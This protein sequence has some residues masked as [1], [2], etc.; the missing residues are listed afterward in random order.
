MILHCDGISWSNLRQKYGINVLALQRGETRISPP[1]G[2]EML[3]EGDVLYVFGR[4]QIIQSL[5]NSKTNPFMFSINSR[6]VLSF[7]ISLNDSV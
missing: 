5:N 7:L 2:E 4:S 1:D 6:A 3:R